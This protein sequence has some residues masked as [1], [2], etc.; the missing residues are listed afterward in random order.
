SR[1]TIRWFIREK[2]RQKNDRFFGGEW[3][4]FL[5]AP[6]PALAAGQSEME[7]GIGASGVQE[8]APR[9]AAGKMRQHLI[10]LIDSWQQIN[11]RAFNP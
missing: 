2:L 4:S 9:K 6:I 11:G 10:P 1:R 8:E 5:K 3:G 7:L